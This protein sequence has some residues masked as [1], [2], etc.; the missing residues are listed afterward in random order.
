MSFRGS[1]FFCL[2]LL[3]LLQDSATLCWGR[4]TAALGIAS[5]YEDE[6][7]VEGRSLKVR[8]NDYGVPS[9]NRNHDPPT[10]AKKVSSS[11]R[12]GRRG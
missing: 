12:G 7:M 6:W 2:L 1:L 8:L 5:E 3:L 11:N 4:P 9:A 10:P